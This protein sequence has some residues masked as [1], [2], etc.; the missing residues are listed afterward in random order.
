MK[1][2]VLQCAQWYI[3]GTLHS[4]NAI[5]EKCKQKRFPNQF[6]RSNTKNIR[7]YEITTQKLIGAEVG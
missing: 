6:D 3:Y 1:K 4:S 7:K 2:N 5:A